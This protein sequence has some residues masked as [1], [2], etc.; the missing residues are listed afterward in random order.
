[1]EKIT[2]RSYGVI[3]YQDDVMMISIEL[4]GY[5]WLE[6]DMLRKAMGK[7]IPEVMAAEKGKLLLGL[8]DNGMSQQKANQLWS[9]IEPF[10]A[11]G[12]NKAH[13][14]SY[15]RVA[16][17]T[18]YMKANFPVE[19]MSAVLTADSG[20]TEKISEIIHECE[21]MGIEVLPPD[22]NESFADFSVVP[23]KETIRFGLTT[24]KN[25]GAGITEVIV[26]ERKTNGP[27]AS[28][29]DFLTR[30][31]DRG[32]NKKSI[33]ALICAGAFDT[34]EDRGQ[35][36]GNVDTL[37]AYNRELVSGKE[38]GQDSLF[39]TISS[40]SN[41][42][43]HP[44]ELVTVMTKLEWEKE[45]LGVYVSGHPLNALKTEV[46]K[47]P[48]IAQIRK[49]YK[50]TTVVTTGLIESVRELLTK[51]G[52]KM[53]FI[54]LVDQTDSIELTAFP[55]VYLEQKDIL[56]PGTCVAI[57]GK[58]DIRNDEPSI[59]IDKAKVLASSQDITE[60]STH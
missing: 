35:L 22:V 17:Q 43:L 51:K 48:R 53:A 44:V 34:F 54:K 25:F 5:S 42:S 12:F 50:G 52:D 3:T 39:A 1:M 26:T 23:G 11:Y 37:L 2:D 15:G 21:R 32:L 8:V 14:A 58:L 7:K 6:A 20:D 49:G 47:R 38:T 13:A 36:F 10:A 18:A 59:L 56:Q 29:Q 4:A 40:V 45:L 27:F 46:D 24:I 16:Y 33:E 30:I 31:H 60:I 41:L 28:L 55:T 19:Y 9:L 57:K